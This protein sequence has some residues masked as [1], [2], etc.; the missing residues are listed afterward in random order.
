MDRIAL[1]LT[2]AELE[3]L[4][5]AA[6]FTLDESVKLRRDEH[7]PNVATL[8]LLDAARKLEAAARMRAPM[9]A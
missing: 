8:D 1:D 4:L 6:T 3:A 7:G 2:R 9:V 5:D